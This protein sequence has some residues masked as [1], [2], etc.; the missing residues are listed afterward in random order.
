MNQARAQIRTLVHTKVEICQIGTGL[1]MRYSDVKFSFKKDHL[2][3]GKICLAYFW[4]CS[5]LGI[6]SQGSNFCFKIVRNFKS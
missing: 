3:K 1:L 6:E 2:T 5:K 4:D